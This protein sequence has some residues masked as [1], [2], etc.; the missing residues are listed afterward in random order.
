[1][2]DLGLLS[3]Q[4]KQL[5]ELLRLLRQWI[6]VIK[7]VHYNIG[8]PVESSELT[9][10]ANGL[11][12]ITTFLRDVIPTEDEGEWNEDWL[13]DP[14]LPTDVVEKIRE[15]HSNDQSLYLQQLRKLTS[16]LEEEPMQLIDQDI[17]MLDGIM[18]AASA[19]VNEVFRRMMRWE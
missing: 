17:E 9:G 7:Q 12:R 1:M 4:Y 5:H 3:K 8:E 16:H 10:A 13:L 19:D 14:P 2:S 18:L 6:T 11:S 15:T